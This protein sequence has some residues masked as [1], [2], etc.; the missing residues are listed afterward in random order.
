[1]P[2]NLADGPGA[3]TP[4]DSVRQEEAL[5]RVRATG[6]APEEPAAGCLPS[7]AALGS[8]GL[9]AACGGGDD[10]V[11]TDLL[12]RGPTTRQFLLGQPAAQPMREHAWA[13]RLP[14]PDELMDWAERTYGSLFPGH[15]ATQVVGD[16]S[17]RGPYATG[18]YMGVQG[19]NVLVLGPVSNNVVASVGNLADFAPTVLGVDQPITANDAARFLGQ[20]AFGGTAADVAAVQRLGFDGWFAAQ[21]AL[22]RSQSHWD[23]M[24]ANGYAVV[25]NTFNFSGVDNTLWRKLMSSPDVL[26]QRVALALSEIFV[27][28][29]DGLPVNWRGMVAAS[30]MDTLETHAFGNYR[31]LLEAVTLSVGMGVYLNMRGNQKADGKGREPDENYA[32]EV[33]QLFTIGLYKLNAD[34]TQQSVNGVPQDTYT[35]DDI[36]G[37]A[38]VFT[39]WDYD[40]YYASVPDHAARPMAFVASRHS[41]ETKSFL[42]VNLPA[43]TDGVG[44]LRVALDTL[45]NHPNV[46]PFICKQLIQRLVTSNP[47]AAYVGRVAAVFANNGQGVRGDLAAVVRAVLLDVEAR[48]PSTQPGGGKLREPMV[49][50]VQWARTFS[51]ASPLGQWNVGNMS[52]ASTRLGQS[53]LRSPSVFNFFRPGYVPPGTTLGTA[54]LTAPEF[55]LTNESTVVGYA[56][57]MQTVVGSGV[58]EVKGDYTPWASLATSPTA[59]FDELNTLLAA[60]QLGVA[61]RATIT[62]AVGSM[63]SA[64]DANKLNRVYATVWLIMCSPEYLVQK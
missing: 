28:S 3:A 55:Q 8:T 57:W 59:L 34:G 17:Y 48:T 10:D 38:R 15:L 63:A 27:I 62:S 18:N 21:F 54:A 45:A 4:S 31:Q 61:S 14:T 29:M 19:N 58:G 46:G 41:P 2:L 6:L 43:G 1:M 60:G 64:T 32:R 20:A 44:E 47:S 35:Q 39:G 25:A 36:K 56:N 5:L 7:V 51:A 42:G 30:Y 9:L 52:S 11:A 33:M 26:R 37:L 22:P 49:R 12:A 53:P 40:R 13:W 24:V 50:L 23:W 16:L